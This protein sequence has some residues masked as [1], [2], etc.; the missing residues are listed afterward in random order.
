MI[1]FNA[2][3]VPPADIVLL[4]P[5]NLAIFSVMAPTQKHNLFY[6]H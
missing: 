4:Y 5:F 2:F 3:T 1:F 6:L